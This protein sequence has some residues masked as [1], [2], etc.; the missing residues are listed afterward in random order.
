V[1]NAHDEWRRLAWTLVALG[2][3][4]LFVQGFTAFVLWLLRT[5]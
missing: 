4:W 5:R 3:F 1:R 2:A